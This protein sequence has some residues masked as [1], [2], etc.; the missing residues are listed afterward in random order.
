VR[1]VDARARAWGGMEKTEKKKSE[2]IWCALRP[3]LAAQNQQTL[4]A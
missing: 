4:N 2:K 3:F 1:K